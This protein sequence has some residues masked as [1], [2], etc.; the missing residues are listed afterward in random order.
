V[1]VVKHCLSWVISISLQGFKYLYLTPQDYTRIS[2]TN[3]VHCHH[4][5]EGGESRYDASSVWLTWRV[6]MWSLWSSSPYRYII[7]D[8]IGKSDGLGVENLRG[9][10]TIAGESSQAYD[11]IITISMVRMWL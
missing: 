9:S 8:V 10:G 11:E 7:T 1:C 5:E 6:E 4:V 3:A 2:S